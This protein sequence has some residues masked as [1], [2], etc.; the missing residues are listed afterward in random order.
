LSPIEYSWHRKHADKRNC[1]LL[2]GMEDTVKEEE[3]RDERRMWTV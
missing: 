2:Y 1:I 3:A